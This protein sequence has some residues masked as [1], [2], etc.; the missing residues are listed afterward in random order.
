MNENEV[1]KKLLEELLDELQQEYD[2]QKSK[3]PNWRIRQYAEG[4]LD[5]HDMAGAVLVKRLKELDQ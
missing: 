5:G 1:K 2:A 4:W 3:T